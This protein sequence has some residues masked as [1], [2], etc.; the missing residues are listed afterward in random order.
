MFDLV[1]KGKYIVRF[2]GKELGT[3][4]TLDEAQLFQSTLGHHGSVIVIP[5]LRD[6]MTQDNINIASEIAKDFTK[7]F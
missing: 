5:N 1:P 6:K 2:D 4:N 3:F 7:G